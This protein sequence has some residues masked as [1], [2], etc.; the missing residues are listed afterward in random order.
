ML[1]GEE[2]G[3]QSTGGAAGACNLDAS[4][5]LEGHHSKAGI[6]MVLSLVR[7]QL[8]VGLTSLL[9]RQAMRKAFMEKGSLFFIM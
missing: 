2:A 6:V 9:P 1:V 4:G 8:D 3:R 5:V 7:L